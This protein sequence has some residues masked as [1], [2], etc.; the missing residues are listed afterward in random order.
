[1]SLLNS[2]FVHTQAKRLAA[3]IDR[4]NGGVARQKLAAAVEQIYSRNATPEEIEDL[5]QL[6]NKL[7]TDYQK[8][9]DESFELACL[10]MLNWNEF[11][12]VD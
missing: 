9:P 10:A 7:K 12:F 8:S 1:M 6:I 11:I 2:E 5:K 4:E 3:K